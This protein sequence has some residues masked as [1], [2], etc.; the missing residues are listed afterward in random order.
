MKY[1]IIGLGIYG[2]NL[3][4]DLAAMGHEIIGAHVDSMKIDE[5]T[6]VL[7]FKTP[8][9]FIGEKYADLSLD[10]YGLKLIALTRATERVNALEVR[11][12]QQTSIACYTPDLR[13]EAG[14]V[15]TVVGP[16]KGART[17]YRKFMH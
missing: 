2:S 11:R 8:E 6:Y 4:L 10:D 12:K 17:L 7:K 3:A 14:D 16:I 13:A 15:M 1:L 9:I 5:D